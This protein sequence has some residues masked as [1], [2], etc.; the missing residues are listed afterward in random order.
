MAECHCMARGLKTSSGKFASLAGLDKRERQRDKPCTRGVRA[1]LA[2]W[3]NYRCL[4]V[5]CKREGWKRF[6]PLRGGRGLR[7]L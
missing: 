1:V 3:W 5:C 6:A 2:H 7:A 4:R